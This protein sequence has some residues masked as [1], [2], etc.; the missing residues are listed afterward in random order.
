MK[1]LS[2]DLRQR[3]LKA[4]DDPEG[5]HRKPAARFGVDTPTITRLLQLRRQ[6][7]SFEPRP[8][9]AGPPPPSIRTAWSGSETSSRRPPMPRPK[10]SSGAWASVAAS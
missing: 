3:I 1:P 10:P 4:V 2:N 5:S 6:A 9:A 7:G 8:T